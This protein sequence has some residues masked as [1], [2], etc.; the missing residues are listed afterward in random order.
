MG[1]L[2]EVMG[3][4]QVIMPVTEPAFPS[5]GKTDLGKGLKETFNARGYAKDPANAF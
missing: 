1:V 5:A 2:T 3:V 4:P